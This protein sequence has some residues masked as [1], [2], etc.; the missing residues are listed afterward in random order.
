M[1]RYHS[2]QAGLS[3]VEIMVA[4]AVSLVLMLGISQVYLSTR[5]SY[6]VMEGASR[7]QENARFAISFLTE[8]LRHSGLYGCRSGIA[9]WGDGATPYMMNTLNGSGTFLYGFEEGGVA[10]QAV[11]GFDAQGSGT[12]SPSIPAGMPS[13]VSTNVIDD[14]DIIVIR[15]A[16]GGGARVAT[17]MG[18]SPANITVRTP[19]DLSDGVVIITDCES[20]AVLSVTGGGSTTLA[21]ATGSEDN[22]SKTPLDLGKGYGTDAEVFSLSTAIYYVQDNDAG[23]PS[24]FRMEGTNAQELVPGVDSFQILYGEDTNFDGSADRYVASDD[25]TLNMLN[26][27]SIRVGLLMRSDEPIQPQAEAFTFGVLD[28]DVNTN[29]RFYHQAVASTISLRNRAFPF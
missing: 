12:W 22:K 15:G 28:E 2:T 27:V 29:D 25:G 24:L 3:L 10:A 17:A 21:P 9:L 4:L 11:Q 23:V 16:R 5:D 7:L 20:S 14:N 8:D 19:I 6:R 18:S 13:D 1:S 26:V